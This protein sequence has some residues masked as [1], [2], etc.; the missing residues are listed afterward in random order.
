MDDPFD[1]M[2]LFVR[3][4]EAGNFTKA[5]AAAGLAKSSVSER[6]AALERRL[7]VRL[8][9]RSTRR[10][11]PTEAGS[12]FYARAR[13]ARAAASAAH[14]EIEALSEEPA[15]LLRVGAVELFTRLHLIPALGE[16][17]E[18]N[19]RMRI[20]FVESVELQDLIAKGLDVAIRIAAE[21]APNTVARRIGNS[22]PVIVASPAYIAERGAPAHPSEIVRH[23]TIGFAPLHWGHEWRFVAPEGPLA[24]PVTPVLLTSS[25]ETLRAGALAGVGLAAIPRWA[26]SDKLASGELGRVLEGFETAVRGIYAIYPSNRFI[27]PK[28][29]QYVDHVVGRLRLIGA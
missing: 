21:P 26:V 10:L 8:L 11:R 18:R 9:E 13:E 4:V 2:D 3:V 25:T 22:E 14:A 24:V 6:I 23:R 27:A 29:R 28:V 7:G 17:L 16:F 12:A 1:G 5:A 20:E 15:G 19:P